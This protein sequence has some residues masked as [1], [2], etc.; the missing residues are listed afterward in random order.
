MVFGGN[1]LHSFATKIQ[2]K[3]FDIENE[4]TPWKFRLGGFTKLHWYAA[5]SLK[6]ELKNPNQNRNNKYSQA[7]FEAV[8][9]IYKFL[10][11]EFKRGKKNNYHEDIPQSIAPQNLLYQLE[12]EIA[13]RKR[14]GFSMLYIFV[15]SYDP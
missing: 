2:T 8:E 15:I 14:F 12:T 4:T 7:K 3:I 9:H 11:K 13:T 5:K 10:Y 6:K 1:C